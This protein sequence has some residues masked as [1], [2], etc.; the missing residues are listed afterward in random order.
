[1]GSSP[2]LTVVSSISAAAPQGQTGPRARIFLLSPANCGGTRAKQVLSPRAA[3][4]LADRLRSSEGAPLGELFAFVSGLYFRGK[5]AYASRFGGPDQILV[6][7]TNRGLL[8]VGTLI[9]AADLR[10]LGTGDISLKDETYRRSL[11][12]DAERLRGDRIVFLGSIATRKYLEVLGHALGAR[13]LV[14]RAFIGMGDMSRGSIL[15]EAA[16][17]GQE[18][19]Y[20]PASAF[21]PAAALV[22]KG[23]FGSASA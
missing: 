1:M 14:P 4:A 22:R 12:R 13:L 18:L 7:S 16:R 17:L 2:E 9:N 20:M 5:L 3:F 21:S 6:I 11:T 10:A 23:E 19:A 15:L 8:P